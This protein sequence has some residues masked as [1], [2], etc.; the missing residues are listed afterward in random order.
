MSRPALPRASSAMSGFFF[1]GSIDEPV[2][3]ASARRR[4]P[5]SSLDHSTISSPR[6]ERCTC[7][8]ASTNSAS[9]TKSRSD[10]ASSELSKRRA[11]PSS[12]GDA[13][14]IE[15]QA[16]AGER[17]GAERRHVGP[18]ERVA[19]AVDVARERPEVREEV[20]RE[21]HRLGALEVRV[22]G[23]VDVAPAASAR[24]SSTSCRR[25]DPARDVG[26]LALAG[27]AA[28]RSRPGR[29]G[30]GRCGASRRRSPASSVTRRSIAVW[31]SSSVGRER[32]R[33]VGELDSDA[34]ERRGHERRLLV[35]EQPD[36]REHR[37]VR[38]RAREVVGREAPVE[39]EALGEREQLVGRAVGEAA[40]PEG[41]Q[42]SGP[43]CSRAHVS[44][45]SPHSRT[46]P[47][48]SWWRNVSD[49]S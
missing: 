42:T 11:K 19:P 26:A 47:S 12:A 36:A 16:R 28:A 10:T 14:G 38:A 5:N 24:S 48:A 39:R 46:K 21:Q 43:P 32:E 7:V 1:C 20:V 45:E 30:C 3:Y 44:T 15:R 6:R 17:A 13:V 29:C 34:V 40:V 4:K 37:D 9:A 25:V 31:M 33:A 27:T 18:R 2:L 22:A 35:G 49:A 23:E 8:S 41:H